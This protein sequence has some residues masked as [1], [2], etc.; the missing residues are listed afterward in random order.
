VYA[1]YHHIAHPWHRGLISSVL[2]CQKGESAG[3][4]EKRL[5]GTE[6]GQTAGEGKGGEERRK[7][8][9]EGVCKREAGCP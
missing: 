5:G 1:A 4:G 2:A 7:K 6:N 3:G 9:C 8:L